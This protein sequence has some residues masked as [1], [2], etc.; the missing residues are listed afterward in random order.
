MKAKSDDLK[1]MPKGNPFSV[2]DG[3]FENL[4]ARV[5]KQIPVETPQPAA[6]KVTMWER[7]SPFLY[8]AAMIGGFGLFFRVIAFIDGPD[9]TGSK[10]DTLLVETARPGDAYGAIMEEETKETEYLEY[11]EEQYT[12][13]FIKSEMEGE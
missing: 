8:L 10:T 11:L 2:P 1:N 12:D 3:Y 13:A 4:T 5:M 7:I 9:A 6:K